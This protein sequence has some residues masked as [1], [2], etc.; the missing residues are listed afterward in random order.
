MTEP[1]ASLGIMICLVYF[2]I[3]ALVATVAAVMLSSL[4]T[5]EEKE[6]YDSWPPND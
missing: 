5:K 4:I 3:A 6:Q 1:L 2:V